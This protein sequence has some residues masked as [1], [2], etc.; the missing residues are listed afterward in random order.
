M[1]NKKAL[2]KINKTFIA[3]V[4]T[5]KCQTQNCGQIVAKSIEV[6]IK[7]LKNTSN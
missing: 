7:E 1:L 3:Y 5:V 2:N 4:R 6:V